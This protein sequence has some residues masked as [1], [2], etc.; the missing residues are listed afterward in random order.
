MNGMNCCFSLYI[1][2]IYVIFLS[3]APSLSLS[4]S[5]TLS[6]PLVMLEFSFPGKQMETDW[7]P[8][9]IHAILRALSHP[10]FLVHPFFLWL[11]VLNLSSCEAPCGTV[12]SLPT[13][14]CSSSASSLPQNQH[15]GL[16][17]SWNDTGN[18]SLLGQNH[19]HWSV[20][21]PVLAP[22]VNHWALHCVT[23]VHLLSSQ[24]AEPK[25]PPQK[26]AHYH[27]VGPAN[28]IKQITL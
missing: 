8:S 27:L 3:S 13:A 23:G 24:E 16:Q 26:P 11:P 15:K 28:Q 5:L 18:M 19:V 2:L 22:C 12:P 10:P 1:R 20:S 21:I 4:L 25:K 7:N 9:S 14:F 17:Q 6:H